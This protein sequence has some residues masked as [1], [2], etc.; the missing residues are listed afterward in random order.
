MNGDENSMYSVTNRLT[1]TLSKVVET[2]QNFQNKVEHEFLAYSPKLFNKLRKLSLINDIEYVKSFQD[3]TQEVFSEGK[4]GS[5]L[6]FSSDLKYLVKTVELEEIEQLIRMLSDYVSHIICNKSSLLPRYLGAYSITMYNLTI[7]FVI[8]LNIFPQD[9][10]ISE[11]YD[12]KGSWVNRHAI[13]DSKRRNYGTQLLNKCPLYKDNDLQGRFNIDPI[14]AEEIV[15]ILALDTDFLQKRNLMDYSLLVGVIKQKF[16]IQEL[17]VR[18]I[19]HNNPFRNDTDGGIYATQVEGP[20][21]FYLGI[22][23]FNNL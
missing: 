10:I 20:G 12:L 22:I 3:V 13:K 15:K 4:S 18:E 1:N 9:T 17:K 11:R 16:T 6:Y 21:K 14:V 8:T 5:F 23:F 19:N 7:N 2:V